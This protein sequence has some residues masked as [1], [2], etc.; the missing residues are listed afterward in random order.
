MSWFPPP[1]EI[2]TRVF[3]SLPETYRQPTHSLWAD[4][5]KFGEAID[6]FLEGPCVDDAGALYVTDIPFGRVFRISADGCDWQLIAQYDGWPN[7]LKIRSD[8]SLLI[9]DYR[10]GLVG[11]DSVSGQVSD[12]L[13]SVRSEGFKGVNDLC[14][15]DN[16]DL[17]FTDQGQ[18]GMHDPTGRIYRQTPDGRLDCLIDTCPSPNGLV[19]A[20][21]GRGLFIALTRSCQ[22]W[23]LPITRDTGV[24]KAQV[25]CQLPGGLAGPDG[26][27]I[28]RE[29]GVLVA[30][31]AHGCV[32]RLDQFGI[33]THRIVACAGR[34]IT[35]LCFGG[36][37]LSQ[38]YMTSSDTGQVLVADAPFAGHP[39]PRG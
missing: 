23:R 14:F 26:L 10:R 1:A 34:S 11:V 25:F 15:A 33:P 30:S 21:D 27:A 19:M 17:Y 28:D 32:W 29:G 35:N 5:N 13:T 24:S 12:M 7:G 4:A 31:P 9:T 36:P 8:G 20:A 6:S 16:G 18:T 37:E 39:V 38:V 3:A 22:V 2:Q